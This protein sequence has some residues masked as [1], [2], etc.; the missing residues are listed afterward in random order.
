[1]LLAAP[2][3]GAWR[4][5]PISE[6]DLQI[7]SA[8]VQEVEQAWSGFAAPAWSGFIDGSSFV[9]ERGVT[10][11]HRF[12]H[13]AQPDRN[14]ALAPQTRAIHHLC[15][16]AAVLRCAP[17][18]RSDPSWWRVVLDSVL[19]TVALLR[20]H[21]ALHAGAF[22]T[23]RGAIAL[24]AASEG[25]KSTLLAE[26]LGRG[27][28]LVADDVL[29]LESQ[30]DGSPLAHPAPPLMTVASKGIPRLGEGA[31]RTICSLGEESWIAVPVCPEP[32]PL[33]ALVVLDR[34]PGSGHAGA[35]PSLNRI[36]N[37]LAPL[38]DSLMSFPI[39]P[40][41]EQARFELA[42]ALACGSGVWR[43]AADP[44]TP[45]SVLADVLLE[46]EL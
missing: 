20:G 19:F 38:L 7:R 31:E 5:R 14:G 16:D 37:P 30:R 4:P 22:T 42:S 12:V 34:G 10:G 40:E 35:R 32:L 33:R 2:P 29:V 44:K 21:E 46:G 17:I 23:G 15:A 36:K 11:D 27:H 28:T 3:P 13:G 41:R 1:M 26:L 6:P 8:S 9:V 24:T 39:T 18:D 43:L 45:P 25:G